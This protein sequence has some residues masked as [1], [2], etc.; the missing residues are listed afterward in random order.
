[1]KAEQNMCYLKSKKNSKYIHEMLK[2]HDETSDTC[3][4]LKE[5][6]NTN[7]VR[8]SYKKVIKMNK[9]YNFKCNEHHWTNIIKAMRTY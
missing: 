6:K 1:M 2:K 8:E 4:F 9:I 7:E 3:E 5:F